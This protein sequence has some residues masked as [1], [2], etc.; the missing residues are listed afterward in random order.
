LMN[1]KESNLILSRISLR[2][3]EALVGRGAAL[4]IQRSKVLYE[5]GDRITE[6]YFVR[7]GFASL[8]AAS[9]EEELVEVAMVGQE[10]VLGAVLALGLE[11]TPYRMF[12]PARAS[13]LSV[14]AERFLEVF[15]CP[16]KFQSLMLRYLGYLVTQVT[17]AAACNTMHS[18]KPRLSKW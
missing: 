12:I 18:I 15:R 7:T 16:G 14:K 8:I 6:V 11:S 13:L 3:R 1:E 10:A 4:D 9:D 17:Q 2:E 5:L